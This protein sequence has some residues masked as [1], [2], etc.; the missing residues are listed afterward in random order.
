M[1]AFMPFSGYF[2]YLLADKLKNQLTVIAVHVYFSLRQ[3]LAT[4][5]GFFAYLYDKFC[6]L[7]GLIKN[8]IVSFFDPR[9][10]D[11]HSI[12]INILVLF[13]FMPVFIFLFVTLVSYKI[14]FIPILQAVFYLRR[15]AVVVRL[16]R[17]IVSF[18][19]KLLVYTFP[20]TGL[21]M[22]AGLKVKAL[23]S[24][25]G[26]EV[27]ITR[28][29]FADRREFMEKY[30]HIF[31]YNIEGLDNMERERIIARSLRFFQSG[32]SDHFNISLLVPYS[33]IQGHP[34]LINAALTSDPNPISKLIAV[35]NEEVIY[36]RPD[37]VVDLDRVIVAASKGSQCLLSNTFTVSNSEYASFIDPRS[38]PGIN[39]SFC[40]DHNISGIGCVVDKITPLAKQL[41]GV[42]EPGIVRREVMNFQRSTFSVDEAGL[43][44]GIVF[45]V[46]KEVIKNLS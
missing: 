7:G 27:Y 42:H 31:V 24:T 16:V 23:I 29:P 3:H 15:V 6:L 30:A 21:S 9:T 26:L 17:F 37:L 13:A 20:N 36:S 25:K 33:N 18:F 35:I 4:L 40:S 44:S 46:F 2:F 11:L 32:L 1:F 19:R 28:I 41:E 10:R 34:L 5:R 39:P 14:I 12:I 38:N 8:K 43:S 45:P 22:I